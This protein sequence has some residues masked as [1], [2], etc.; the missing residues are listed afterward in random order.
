MKMPEYGRI[1]LGAIF[2]GASRLEETLI[3]VTGESLGATLDAQGILFYAW[4][5]DERDGSRLLAVTGSE[6]QEKNAGIVSLFNAASLTYTGKLVT[7]R[8]QLTRNRDVLGGEQTLLV[9][10]IE[11]LTHVI[12]GKRYGKS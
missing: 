8:G 1:E 2:R 5:R 11:Y 6:T 3:E 10:Q 9:H 12:T 4:L 7:V